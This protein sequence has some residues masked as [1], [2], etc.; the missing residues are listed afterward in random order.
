MKKLLKFLMVVVVLGGVGFAVTEG[1]PR[2]FVDD[3][4]GVVK[5]MITKYQLG[6]FAERI[7]VEFGSTG[8]APRF[9]DEGDF[10][11]WVEREFQE[12]AGTGLLDPWGRPYDAVSPAEGVYVLLSLGQNGY[13]DDACES[14]AGAL[15]AAL[16]AVVADAWAA[17]GDGAAGD[18]ICVTVDL[19][20]RR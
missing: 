14:A 18:D 17:D 4:V 16:G 9:A 12:R 10:A 1:D 19:G 6:G 13:R 15:D 2:A 11:A 5:G 7:R 8:K 20:L 3:Q